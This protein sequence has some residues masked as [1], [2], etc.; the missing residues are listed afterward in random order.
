LIV[1]QTEIAGVHLLMSAPGVR[2]ALGAP[3]AVRTSADGSRRF[4][5]GKTKVY[6]SATGD[7]T[8]FRVTTTDRRQKTASGAGVGSSRAAIARTVRGARCS[9]SACVV[10]A[11]RVTRFALHDGRVVRITLGYVID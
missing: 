2:R 10:G 5:Y 8:V 11:R 9:A 7:G 1:P 4:D 6:I 3:R